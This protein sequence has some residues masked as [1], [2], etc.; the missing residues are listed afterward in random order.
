ML[1]N[2]REFDNDYIF[3]R[4]ENFAS[5]RFWVYFIILTWV[6]KNQITFSIDNYLNVFKTICYAEWKSLIWMV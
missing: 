5:Y 3:L 1:I 6:I 2:S 4:T